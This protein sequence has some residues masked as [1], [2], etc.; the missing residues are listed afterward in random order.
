MTKYLSDGNSNTKTAKNKRDTL[1]LYLAPLNQN[2]HGVNMCPK[3]SDGCAVAC[4]F[5]A[6]RGVFSNVAN[7]RR[8]K[9]DAFLSDRKAFLSSVAMQINKRAK[10]VK[11][12]AVRLNG[13]SDVKLVEQMTGLYEIASNVIFYDYTK[14]KQKAG[15]RV[16][17][18]GHRYVVT[19]SRSEVNDNEAL[20]IL[21]AGGIVAVVFDK[22]PSV[23]NG[24]RVVDGDSRD[25]LMLDVRGAV[26][27]GLKAKG[28]A[29]YDE[30]GFV[31]STCTRTEFNSVN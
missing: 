17:S 14:I 12:L 7:A 9:T 28:K 2:S 24:F 15:R 1:I 16:L 30:S 4:L 13:T 10:S 25:D 20:D 11:Q 23:W 29:R 8:Q 22:I 6:G 18:S 19:F 21:N 26:V 5:T 3:A 31:V 27:L